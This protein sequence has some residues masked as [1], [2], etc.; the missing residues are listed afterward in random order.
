MLELL[1]AFFGD[2]ECW[3]QR[4][5]HDGSGRRCLLGAL[6]HIEQECRID[7]AAARGYLRDAIRHRPPLTPLAALLS[8]MRFLPEDTLLSVFNDGCGNFREVRAVIIDALALA[9]AELPGA[10]SAERIP[11]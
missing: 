5:R 4:T 2:G 9:Q 3:I 10:A 1:L 11:A 7:D 6:R 8:D